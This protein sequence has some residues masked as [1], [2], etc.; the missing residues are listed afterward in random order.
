[1]AKAPKR[2]L[3]YAMEG[4]HPKFLGEVMSYSE[5]EWQISIIKAQG[6][7]NDVWYEIEKED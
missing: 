3:I 5:A 2:Y 7:Y 6:K 1:M 4:H